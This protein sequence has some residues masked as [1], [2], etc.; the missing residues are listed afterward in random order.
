MA[1]SFGCEHPKEILPS[2]SS[3]LVERCRIPQIHE[4]FYAITPRRRF[5]NP[6]L[7]ELLARRRR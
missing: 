2:N 3:T 6:L 5:P 4:S 1:Q 7:R